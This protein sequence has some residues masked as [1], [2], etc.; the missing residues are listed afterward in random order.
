MSHTMYWNS[1]LNVNFVANVIA[2]IAKV[3]YFNFLGLYE[4]WAKARENIFAALYLHF[5]VRFNN[6]E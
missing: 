2:L 4:R 1:V 6:L 3:S 5:S